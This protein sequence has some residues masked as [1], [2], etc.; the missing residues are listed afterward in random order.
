MMVDRDTLGALAESSGEDVTP[1]A[2]QALSAELVDTSMEV[3]EHV[4][5]AELVSSLVGGL[6]PF[7][8][9][10]AGRATSEGPMDSQEELKSLMRGISEREASRIDALEDTVKRI[11]GIV[12]GLAEITQGLTRIAKHDQEDAEDT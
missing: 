10:T 5:I 3:K 2:V 6:C 9:A 7:E 8:K 1:F 11:L 12:E 4:E